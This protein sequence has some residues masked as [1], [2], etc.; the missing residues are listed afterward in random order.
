VARA[1]FRV[2]DVGRW[3]LGWSVAIAVGI[4]SVLV[5][6]VLAFC[7]QLQPDA[8]TTLS[9]VGIAAAGLW[10]TE[11][12]SPARAA[13]WL[14][15]AVAAA[16]LREHGPLLLVCITVA[17]VSHRRPRLAAALVA[18]GIAIGV[19]AVVSGAA[20]HLPARVALPLLESPLGAGSSALPSYSEELKGPAGRALADA[21][22]GGDVL[23]VWTIL[24]ERLVVRSGEN[25]VWIALGA[26]GFAVNPPTTREQGTRRA[27][28]AGFVGL[29]PTLFL[30]VI[31]SHRRHTSVLLPVAFLGIG[32]LVQWLATKH[33]AAWL[34]GAL[35]IAAAIRS[36][37]GELLALS[38]AAR[39]MRDAET[40]AAWMATQPGEWLLGGMHNEV[41][42]FL[43]WPRHNPPL[44]PP[45]EPMPL[46]WSAV[47][48]RTQ[49]VAPVGS[50]PPPYTT[51][52]TTE[53]L[54]VF[55]LE[56]PTG[57]PRPC[58][59]S[60]PLPGPLMVIGHV[61]GAAEPRCEAAPHFFPPPPRP[62]GPWEDRPWVP[63]EGR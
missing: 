3:G 33:R 26:V 8:L 15:S 50:M 41:N 57:T 32:L 11:Q 30:L 17:L 54:A 52:R 47:D 45:D 62:S 21:W 25:L 60:R 22:Q 40:L 13:L 38:G 1:R 16:S 44:P 53:T 42:L 19:V 28:I 10:W 48:W 35:G 27:W 12:P 6:D 39:H 18:A 23:T 55:R 59:D 24:L 36:T 37:P 7:F 29:A 20:A 5:P 2:P 58:G 4:T 51:V 34:L 14:A 31:W 63:P 9:I 43:S 56:P 61:T 46:V 49:W